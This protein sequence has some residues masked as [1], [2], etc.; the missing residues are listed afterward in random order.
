MLNFKRLHQIHSSET[1]QAVVLQDGQLYTMNGRRIPQDVPPQLLDNYGV[2]PHLHFLLQGPTQAAVQVRQVNP[3]AGQISAAYAPPPPP[4]HLQ[5]AFNYGL[6]TEQPPAAPPF[7]V[8]GIPGL[9]GV[10]VDELAEAIQILRSLKARATIVPPG[11]Q[12]A[13]PLS[14]LYA[15]PFDDPSDVHPD[16]PQAD[17]RGMQIPSPITSPLGVDILGSIPVQHDLPPQPEL[18]FETLGQGGIRQRR[19]A[20]QE[21]VQVR[22]GRAP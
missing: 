4:R 5:P 14:P 19:P 10:Q 13:N 22:V 20:G 12:H 6:P 2:P 18:D 1:K 15:Q 7:A 11:A 21:R 16:A 9:E 17:L 3:F 8:A